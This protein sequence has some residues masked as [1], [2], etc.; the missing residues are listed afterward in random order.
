MSLGGASVPAAAGAPGKPWSPW[1]DGHLLR[2]LLPERFRTA[3]QSTAG[4]A[5]QSTRTHL[6]VLVNGLW[7]SPGNWSVV[8]ERL[9]EELDPEEFLLHASQVGGRRGAAPAR[10]PACQLRHAQAGANRSNRAARFIS[11]RRCIGGRPG[12]VR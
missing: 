9:R 3:A 11:L 10:L 6:V 5:A 4:S 7:G 8:Q 2:A 12:H 1:S